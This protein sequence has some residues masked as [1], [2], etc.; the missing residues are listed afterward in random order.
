MRIAF[1][2]NIC[3]IFYQIA[4]AVRGCSD[5]DAHLF[6]NATDHL[7]FLPESD[8]PELSTSMPD[9]IHR[10]D[11]Q[12][13]GW[14]IAPWKSSLVSQLNKFDLI[15]T[16]DM[17][18]IVAQFAGRPM[19]FFA[20]GGDLTAYPFP[21]R[22]LYLYSTWKDRAGVVM[23]GF[24]QRR[25]LHRMKEIWA[26]PLPM[27]L[28]A[29]R[30]LQID[31]RRIATTYFPVVL[32]S[33]KMVFRPQPRFIP[34][35]LLPSPD[36]PN[37]FFVFHPTRI[38]IDDYSAKGAEG[39]GKGNLFLFRGF[40][41]FIHNYDAKNA[42]LV[43][44]DRDTVMDTPKAKRWFAENGLANHVIWLT[45]PRASGF[46]RNELI[47][48][49]SACDVVADQ[50]SEQ[51]GF[52]CIA[53]EACSCSRPVVIRINTDYISKLYPWHP[54][55][56]AASPS[57]ITSRLAEMFFSPQS[58]REKGLRSRQWIEQFHSYEATGPL[59][60]TRLRQLIETASAV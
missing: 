23:K 5:I 18:P 8:D 41:D 35:A 47:D 7:Q 46:T 51:G 43:L 25:A 16:G 30:D 21:F 29:L 15:V 28:H 37:P 31:A 6:V 59:Y 54:F 48:I 14:F 20:M 40:A 1:Y 3:N 27:N 13:R 11:Y 24:W 53:L 33:R 49:Y 55:L 60:A 22:F 32:D 39:Q 36:N 34:E 17:G 10:G 52:G 38:Q 19:V 12:H 44:I 45:P 26:H 57:E 58:R 9:W 4:K 50:F 2:G 42:R 56:E